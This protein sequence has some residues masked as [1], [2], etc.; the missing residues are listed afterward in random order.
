MPPGVRQSALSEHPNRQVSMFALATTTA[1]IAGE[2]PL[3]RAAIVVRV[4]APCT[5][6]N[7]LRR[8]CRG[9]ALRRWLAHRCRRRFNRLP[10]TRLAAPARSMG[11][12]T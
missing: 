6:A 4:G 9:A 3:R 12:A 7:V 10:G 5:V 2:E 11:L 8:G 1:F